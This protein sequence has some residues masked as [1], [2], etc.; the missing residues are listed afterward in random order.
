M[1]APSFRPDE[2]FARELDEADPLRRFRNEFLFPKGEGGEPVRYFAGN[3]L[4]LEPRRARGA[5][6]HELEEWGSRGVDGHLEA[7]TPWYTYHENVRGPLARLVGAHEPEVVAMNGLTVNLHLLLVSFYR[8][9]AERYKIVIEDPVFPSDL[10]AVKTQI[11]HHGLDPADALVQVRPSPGKATVDED[12]LEAVLV[13]EGERVALLWIGGVNFLTGRRYDL[14]RLTRAAHGVGALAGFDLAHAAGNV[15]LGLHDDDVDFA[16]WCSYKYLNAGPGATAGAY[17][18]ERHARNTELPRFGGWWGNDPATRFRMQL[19]PEFVPVPSAD[20]WQ[21]SNP[22]VLALAPLRASLELFEEAGMD[23]LRA[24]SERLTG[25]L[26]FL[27]TKG[28]SG[29]VRIVT[30]GAPE[31]RGC[32]LSL[33]IEED[34][35]GV[36]R[37]LAEK[38][39]VCDF[40][41]PNVVRAAPTPLYNTFHDVWTLARVLNG[42]D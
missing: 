10:Y 41:E 33:T 13:R 32:Q 2:A 9:T 12:D 42:G 24:K 22:P 29:S 27:L 39:L 17:V 26:E 1:S 19:E 28:G 37:A 14:G 23:A 36:Q 6:L 20:A 16:V 35:R 8:P 25:Y 40:R 31:Q 34:A 18:H 7:A 21:L 15:P 30:P 3:S 4:G 5:I 11:R 38:G